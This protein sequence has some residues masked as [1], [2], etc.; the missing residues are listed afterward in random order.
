[1]YAYPSSNRPAPA[2]RSIHDQ[3]DW[4]MQ[5]LAETEAPPVPEATGPRAWSG[6]DIS[7]Q[8]MPAQGFSAG[9]AEPAYAPPEPRSWRDVAENIIAQLEREEAERIS[10][11]GRRP[12]GSYD[13]AGGPK[14]PLAPVEEAEWPHSSFRRNPPQYGPVTDYE[15]YWQRNP[16]TGEWEQSIRYRGTGPTHYEKTIKQHISPPLVHEYRPDHPNP[17]VKVITRPALP[18]E[19]PR[20]PAV[21][22]SG[23]IG[24]TPKVK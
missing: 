14:H 22:G 21:G 17:N 15:K 12:D 11:A 10:G 8:P 9:S 3:V 23:S 1:M 16:R 19:I 4:I 18:Y 24:I 6:Y 2:F 7:I 13:V 20:L 5:R